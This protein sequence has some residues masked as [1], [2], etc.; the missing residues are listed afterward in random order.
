MIFYLVQINYEF[1]I[2]KVHV[3]EAISD[4]AGVFVKLIRSKL[5]V[6]VFIMHVSRL[7]ISP[8]LMHSF[9]HL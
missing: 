2:S 7:T 6:S 8:V 3:L 9:I 1:N 4:S 5:C